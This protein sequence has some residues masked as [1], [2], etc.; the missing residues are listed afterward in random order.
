MRPLADFERAFGYNILTLRAE[1]VTPQRPMHV[2]E[3]RN[4]VLI[5]NLL[6]THSLP[7]LLA[8]WARWT[9]DAPCGGHDNAKLPRE[10]QLLLYWMDSVLGCSNAPA[11]RLDPTTVAITLTAVIGILKVY[12]EASTHPLQKAPTN[13]DV[14]RVNEPVETADAV[15]Q[16]L[17]E[18]E[19][20]LRRAP[21]RK[22]VRRGTA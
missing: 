9:L 17:E 15:R 1:P 18:Y 6:H 12:I 22:G 19:K 21:K 2:R 5:N 14:A 7:T 16:A 3:L 20:V 8:E 4:L 13:A 10:K 11:A